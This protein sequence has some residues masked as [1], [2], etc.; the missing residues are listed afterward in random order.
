MSGGREAEGGRDEAREGSGQRWGTDSQ[1]VLRT[2]A[3]PGAPSQ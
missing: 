3:P 1:T 2:S